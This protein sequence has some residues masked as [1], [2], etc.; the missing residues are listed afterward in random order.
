MR[1]H[2]TAERQAHR[3]LAS[4]SRV[5]WSV[6]AATL[7]LA[8]SLILP[9]I[10]VG[11]YVIRPTDVLGSWILVGLLAFIVLATV[12]AGRWPYTR[13]LAVVPLVSGC[14][15]LGVLG[16][17]A[18]AVRA[19]NPLL[20]SLPWQEANDAAQTASRLAG[21]LRLSIDQLDRLSTIADRFMREPQ[22]SFHA[23]SGLFGVSALALILDRLP[24][25]RRALRPRQ[26]A[27]PPG[28]PPHAPDTGTLR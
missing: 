19:L 15:L 22:L 26:P 1:I 4:L 5:D 12:V 16:G 3:P 2:T 24:Q 13:W 21:I 11:G 20:A 7:L 10:S 8:W 27:S 6:V 23:G 14:L 18:G 25:N 9:W 28:A 17:V